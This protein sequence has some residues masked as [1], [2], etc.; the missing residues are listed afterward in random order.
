MTAGYTTGRPS[1]RCIQ[2]IT[3]WNALV[4]STQLLDQCRN[5]ELIIILNNPPEY[6]TKHELTSSKNGQLNKKSNI[7]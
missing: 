6:G 5:G 2:G 4:S 3:D 7:T 1:S